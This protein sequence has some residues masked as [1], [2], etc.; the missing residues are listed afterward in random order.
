MKNNFSKKKT[1]REVTERYKSAR[2]VMNIYN[3]SDECENLQ[4]FLK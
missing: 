1:V 4:F 2:H 3:F